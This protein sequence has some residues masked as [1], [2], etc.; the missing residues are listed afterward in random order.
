MR[1]VTDRAFAI[2]L[3]RVALEGSD[4]FLPRYARHRPA[5]R[6][7]ARGRFYE[8]ET[9]RL[10]AHVLAAVPGS[11]VHAGTFFG[12]MIPDFARACAPAGRLYCFEPLLENYVLARLAVDANGLENVLLF[13]SALG[14]GLGFCRIAR[15]GEIHAGGASQVSETGEVSATVVTVDSLGLGQLSI[16]QLDVEGF[17]VPALEGARDTIARL[18]PLVMLEDNRRET[19]DPMQA[20]GYRMARR[21]AGLRIWC[22]VERTDLAAGLESFA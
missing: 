2:P 22:P 6:A 9:H 16:L 8:P 13:N 20:A 7:L 11:M 5:V 15:G 12:D 17:E 21:I 19:A 18:R 1:F 14:A 4:Y 10:V 3:K